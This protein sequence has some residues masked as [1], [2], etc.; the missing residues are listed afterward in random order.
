MPESEFVFGSQEVIRNL[1]MKSVVTLGLIGFW[2]ILSNELHFECEAVRFG[3]ENFNWFV[4][5][6]AVD[7]LRFR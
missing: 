4:L 3:K 2:F 6:A 1:T 5:I 7:M